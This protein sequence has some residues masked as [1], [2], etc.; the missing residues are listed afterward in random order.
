MFVKNLFDAYVCF[1]FRLFVCKCCWNLENIVI[2]C[3]GVLVSGKYR[4]GKPTNPVN[5]ALS[6]LHRFQ[7]YIISVCF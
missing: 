4:H 5:T 1:E 2:F 3:Q 7:N 6:A